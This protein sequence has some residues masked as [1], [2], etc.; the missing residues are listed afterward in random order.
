MCGSGRRYKTRQMERGNTD[1]SIS[2]AYMHCKQ[3]WI[4]EEMLLEAK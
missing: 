2:T 4:I 1:G 3:F